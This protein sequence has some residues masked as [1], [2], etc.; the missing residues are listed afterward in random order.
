[1]VRIWLMNHYE[2]PLVNVN[3]YGKIHQFV[4]GKTHYFDWAIF[5]SYFDKLPEATFSLYP[6][7]I[8][9]SHLKESLVRKTSMTR[10]FP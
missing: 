1:M 8:V 2:F 4:A 6:K 9:R 10:W 7:K 5:N 3:N